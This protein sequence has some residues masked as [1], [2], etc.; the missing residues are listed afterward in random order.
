MTIEGKIVEATPI[1]NEEMEIAS[2]IEDDIN[3]EISDYVSTKARKEFVHYLLT[4][5]KLSFRNP[6]AAE[7]KPEI[8]QVLG[9]TA[10]EPL[11]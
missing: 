7:I 1:T 9:K 11:T 2:K 4:E 3:R 5:Y 10:A 6:P 8:E